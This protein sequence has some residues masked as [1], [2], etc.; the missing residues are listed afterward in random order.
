MAL[1]HIPDFPPAVGV[2]TVLRDDAIVSR[3]GAD[4]R[5]LA[6]MWS[7]D[8]RLLCAM[9]GATLE[10]AGGSYGT[11]P[12]MTWSATSLPFLASAFCIAH[13]EA[14]V[15]CIQLPLPGDTS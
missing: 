2:P 10:T 12:I 13:R 9:S 7:T 5:R 8:T 1:C 4:C 11:T 6:T 3:I 15:M 14:Y